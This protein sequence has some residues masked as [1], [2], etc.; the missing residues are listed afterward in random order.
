MDSKKIYI[1]EVTFILDLYKYT[2]KEKDQLI[3]SI[4]IWVDTREKNNKWVTDWF[5][6]HKITYKSKALSN[7][8]Y[9]FYIPSNPELNIERTLD[10][11]HKIM[12]ERK[13]N[14]DELSN[15]FTT[16]R[17]R[18]QEEMATF[19]GKKYLLIENSNFED[20]INHNYDSKFSP[21][22]YLASIQSF[23]HHYGL[24]IMY[25]PNKEF[26]AVWIYSIF[27]YYLRNIMR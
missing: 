24:E 8:D 19:D 23:N 1:C 5:D 21:K 4:G 11:S 18:F 25:M 17:S 15:N 22:A 7:G 20:I 6:K 12:I 10:F 13:A 14:L 26:S 2:D 9:S 27:V 3:K 16:S